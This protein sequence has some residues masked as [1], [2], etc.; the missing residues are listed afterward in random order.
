MNKPFRSKNTRMYCMLYGKIEKR[1][2]EPSR[3]GIGTRLNVAR[4]KF[5]K[6]IIDEM[7]VKASPKFAE[8]PKRISSPKNRAIQ[9]LDSGPATATFASPHL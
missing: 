7:Y 9:T 3:G 2:F 8:I 1:I 4:T 5:I 6:T